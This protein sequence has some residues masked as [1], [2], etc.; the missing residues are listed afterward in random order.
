MCRIQANLDVKFQ[1]WIYKSKE[2]NND[3]VTIVR[4]LTKIKSVNI[5]SKILSWYMIWYDICIWFFINILVSRDKLYWSTIYVYIVSNT[6]KGQAKTF[7][8]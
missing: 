7:V 5:W 4:Q 8:I 2:L 6:R 3:A 1:I